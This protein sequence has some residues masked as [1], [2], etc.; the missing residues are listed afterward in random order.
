MDAG[1]LNQ[2]VTLL[3]R[4]VA[5]SA[6][7]GASFEQFVPAGTVWAQMD[8]LSGSE[9]W[10]AAQRFAS[11]AMKFRIRFGPEVAPTWRLEWRGQRWDVVEVLPGGQQLRE[12]LDITATASPAENPTT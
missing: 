12:W 7:T 1:R 4:E 9:A 6:T 10:T 5:T 11:T 3:R 2:R 8:P